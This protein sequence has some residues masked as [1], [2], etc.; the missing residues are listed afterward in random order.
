[1]IATSGFL[2]SIEC[3]KDPTS[4]GK[5]R[6]GQGRGEDA[7]GGEGMGGVMRWP[8]NA[9]SWIRPCTRSCDVSLWVA[10]KRRAGGAVGVGNPTIFMTAQ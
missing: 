2:T 3:N 7:R 10:V 4:K 1:M 8:P 9:K 6:G 5:R